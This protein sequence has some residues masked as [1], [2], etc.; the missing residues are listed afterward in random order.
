MKE[1]IK[2]ASTMAIKL[3]VMYV[4]T[5]ASMLALM[6]GIAKPVLGVGGLAVSIIVL[7]MLSGGGTDHDSGRNET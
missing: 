1:M 2:E 4:F 3:F 7:S 6:I 5:M